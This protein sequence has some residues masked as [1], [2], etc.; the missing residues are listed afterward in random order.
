MQHLRWRSQLQ[1]HIRE[2]AQLIASREGLYACL[3]RMYLRLLL[4]LPQQ[5]VQQDTLR[6]FDRVGG[7]AGEGAACKG[8]AEEALREGGVACS[9]RLLRGSATRQEVKCLGVEVGVL[10]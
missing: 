5:Q 2:A 10:I 4:R 3:V 8:H 1:L 7:A 9:A 6:E